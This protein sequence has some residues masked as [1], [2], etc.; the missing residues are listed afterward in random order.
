MLCPP[1]LYL[2][3]AAI[4]PLIIGQP[5]RDY[6]PFAS[7]FLLTGHIPSSSEDDPRYAKTWADLLFVA[8]YIIFFS[9]LRQILAVNIANIIG[10]HYD[11]PKRKFERF[12]EQLHALFYFS[13]TGSVGYVSLFILLLYSML[14]GTW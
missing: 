8:Y 2:L 7:V 3:W 5:A 1:V 9:F 4:A 11:I 10:R 12:G 13:I 14:I 6:N